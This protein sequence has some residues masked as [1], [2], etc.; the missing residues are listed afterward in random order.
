[1]NGR[2]HHASATSSSRASSLHSRPRLKRARAGYRRSAAIQAGPYHSCPWQPARVFDIS[3]IDPTLGLDFVPDR[4]NSAVDAVNINKRRVIG[5]VSGFTGPAGGNNNIA[6]PNG[7]QPTGDG[8]VWAGDGNSTVKI[9]DERSL[10]IVQTIS[11]GGTMRADSIGYDPKDHIAAVVNDADS[12]PFVT[13]IYT[14]DGYRQILKR[15]SF[16]DATNGLEQPVFDPRR[17]VF[18][19]SVPQVGPNQ[20]KG[21][22]AIVDPVL[23]RVVGTLPVSNC[24]PNGAALGPKQQLLLGCSVAN[25]AAARPLGTQVINALSGRLLATFT[26]GGSDEV[27]YDPTN[28][29][30]DL[31]ARNNATGPVLGIIDASSLQLISAIPTAT[32]S[33][34]VAVDR[35]NNEIFFPL[36]AGV[37]NT[38][39]PNGCI[40]VYAP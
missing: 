18:Y 9:I 3:L 12:P 16:P 14:P 8:Y 25:N 19:L 36:T 39:C 30:F 23:R 5:Q 17:G 28:Q 1:M 2:D 4:S 26:V 21:E 38:V 20:E 10:Q 40:G 6:G 11:T 24:Q 37:N 33:H 29:T 34:S 27:S 15:I 13:L 32:N 31:A 7:T 22:V 35:I